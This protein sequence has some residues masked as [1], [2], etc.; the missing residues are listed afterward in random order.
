[1]LNLT[2]KFNAIHIGVCDEGALQQANLGMGLIP[3]GRGDVAPPN[4]GFDLSHQQQEA[5]GV[6]LSW[7]YVGYL[8]SYTFCGQKKAR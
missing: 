7:R 8:Q 3:P 4:P 5:L 6:L 1:M 2:I